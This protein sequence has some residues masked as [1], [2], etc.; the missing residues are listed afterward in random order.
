MIAQTSVEFLIILA[1]VTALMVL[2]LGVY[3]GFSSQ[4][5]AGF[6]ALN[7]MVAL[8][9]AP[10]QGMMQ[11]QAAKASIYLPSASY[12]NITN[13]AYLVVYPGSQ[14]SIRKAQ[15]DSMGALFLPE[16]Y[17]GIGYQDPYILYFSMLPT[18]DGLIRVNAT[19]VLQEGNNETLLSANSTTFSTQWQGNTTSIPVQTASASISRRSE[20]LSYGIANS[21]KI[22]SISQSTS[23]TRLNFWANP[24]PITDQ[25]GNA[26]WM[27]RIYTA[28]CF[29]AGSPS[30]TYCFYK[31]YTGRSTGRISASYDATYNI[32]LGLNLGGL[33]L[34][35]DLTS[36][37]A[38]STIEGSGKAYGNTAVYGEVIGYGDQPSQG[39]AI[40][41]APGSSY[42]IPLSYYQT[43]LQYWNN[44]ESML[45]YY[46][47]SLV[48]EDT[49]SAI[50]QSVSANNNYLKTLF[51]ASAGQSP[52]NVASSSV[53]CKPSAPLIYT[54]I[55]VALDSA[56]PP[57]NSTL[58]VEGSTV[59][60]R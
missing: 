15:L 42:L 57:W 1:A 37:K 27:V 29:S 39:L 2:V 19:V 48:S 17:S 5:E 18:K 59:N 16:N 44:L 11:S 36:A 30:M 14:G 40:M 13:A 6:N 47:N 22:F 45:G 56:L 49:L 52:C 34:T 10:G 8:N 58:N 31:N 43:S 51:N 25:C 32:T 9:Q 60:I 46:N 38:S 7:G 50:Q 33:A 35:S 41:Q 3:S 21:T 53:T 4:Q 55:T 20:S 54:N 26:S 28:P 23:C 12:T 24:L